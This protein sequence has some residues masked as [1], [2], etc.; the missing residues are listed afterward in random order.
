MQVASLTQKTAFN[1]KQ[2]LSY[3]FMMISLESIY[4]QMIEFR[5]QPKD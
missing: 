2:L 5:P 3:F 4:F 1:F